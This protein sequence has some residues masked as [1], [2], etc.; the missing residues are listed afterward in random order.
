M[1]VYRLHNKQT[2]SLDHSTVPPAPDS[3][4][5]GGQ[6]MFTCLTAVAVKVLKTTSEQKVPST[7]AVLLSGRALQMYLSTRPV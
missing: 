3:C 2:L 4:R 6:Q 7:L 1:K 5:S